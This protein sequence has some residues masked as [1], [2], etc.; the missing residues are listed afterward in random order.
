VD[1]ARKLTKRDAGGNVTQRGI[2]V[3]S[4]GFPY[5]LF[6]GFTTQNDVLLMNEAGTETYYDKPAVVEALQSWVDL[7][8][9]HKVM[10]PGVI[11]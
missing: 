4:S 11:E 9:K 1:Y 2:Q 5:W 7:S 10:A 6:Q 8:Q 3:P